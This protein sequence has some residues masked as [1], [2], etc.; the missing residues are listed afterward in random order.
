MKNLLIY[1]FQIL[2]PLPILFWTASQS[3]RMFVVLMGIYIIYRYFVDGYKLFRAG[4][5]TNRER[6]YPFHS[7]KHFKELYFE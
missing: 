5:I 4:V 3:S 1:Y 7:I 6:Y 2:L